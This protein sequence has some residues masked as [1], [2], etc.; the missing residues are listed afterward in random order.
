MLLFWLLFGLIVPQCHAA[1]VRALKCGKNLDWFSSFVTNVTYNEDT[2]LMVLQMD[3]LALEDIYDVNQTTNMYTTLHFHVKYVETVLVDEYLRFCDHIKVVRNE[4]SES[5]FSNL[6]TY[7]GT[8]TQTVT[9]HYAISGDT[10]TTAASTSGNVTS[11]L[12]VAIQK[13]LFTSNITSYD[14]YLKEFEP[15]QGFSAL[16]TLPETVETVQVVVTSTVYSD[17]SDAT[18]TLTGSTVTT[19]STACPVYKDNEVV[20]TLQADVGHRSPFGTYE[21]TIQIIDADNDHTVIG[22]N[23]IYVSTVQDE[24]LS[25]FISAFFAIIMA[26]IIISNTINIWLSPYQDSEDPFLMP[27]AMICN[28]PLLNQETPLFTDFVYYLH[29]LF[30]MV[31]LNIYYPGFVAP[32]FSSFRWV[33]LFHTTSVHGNSEGNVY[34]TLYSGGLKSLLYGS[35]DSQLKAVWSY[36]LRDFGILVAAYICFQNAIFFCIYLYRKINTLPVCQ[37]YGRSAFYYNMGIIIDCF[38]HV[39]AIPLLTVSFYAVSTNHNNPYGGPYI[40]Y[41]PS[42]TLATAGLVIAFYVFQLGY[43]GVK[44]V[45]KKQGRKSLYTSLRVILTWHT[46]YSTFNV[47]KV[48][49]YLVDGLE[50]LIFSVTV[51]AAQASGAAQVSIIIAAKVIYLAVLCICKPYY[52]KT[53]MNRNKIFCCVANVIVS[54]M[55]IPFIESVGSGEGVRTKCIWIILIIHLLVIV[56]LFL[57]PTVQNIYVCFKWYY[58]YR[59]G[60]KGIDIPD[61]RVGGDRIEVPYST[62]QYSMSSHGTFSD[63]VTMPPLSPSVSQMLHEQSDETGSVDTDSLHLTDS[64]AVSGLGLPRP[65]VPT[66]KNFAVREADMYYNAHGVLRPDP[67]VQQ[68][69]EERGRKLNKAN[70]TFKE[71]ARN[72]P[73]EK[74][75][76]LDSI[77]KVH[78]A[79]KK[80]SPP[81]FEV[82]RPTPLKRN[83]T[84]DTKLTMDTNATTLIT[85][86]EA[87]KEVGSDS[88][89]EEDTPDTVP[90]EREVTPEVEETPETDSDVFDDS[91]DSMR[92][93]TL[94]VV[95]TSLSH[96]TH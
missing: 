53:R 19:T 82:M 87:V 69:W 62:D 68:L 5:I 57:F 61:Y 27:A 13:R 81:K 92:R 96:D 67:E 51:G 75:T 78:F 36:L 54:L 45:F 32:L 35:G 64:R 9:S 95:N 58:D 38:S 4:S 30:F 49:F 44:Y 11:S 8:Y 1:L 66:T 20:L 24:K 47:P 40:M 46:L 16:V 56:F 21:A 84:M 89:S 76:W 65:N 91:K 63:M 12:P 83:L 80:A 43:F 18:S 55:H 77:K 59:K 73:M 90:E 93:S 60:A 71:K 85:D 50:M 31:G 94:H 7:D 34:Q 22:C 10:T 2:G 25:T 28:A 79:P 74:T 33:A 17:D 39:A 52:S 72:P 26:L 41:S 14:A 86:T 23:R 6:F 42:W 48:W 3:A 70:E 15:S 37:R 29:F 88:W